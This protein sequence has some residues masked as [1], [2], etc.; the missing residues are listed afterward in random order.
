MLDKR[1][2]TNFNTPCEPKINIK[3][4]KDRLEELIETLHE[5]QPHKRDDLKVLHSTHL[6]QVQERTK[7]P[8]P[9]RLSSSSWGAPEVLPDQRVS[10]IPQRVL[11]LTQ[12]LPLWD[13]KTSK[14]RCPDPNLFN[15][16]Q[17][18]SSCTP[19]SSPHL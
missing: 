5:L 13:R 4:F 16:L 6:Q 9:Q 11:G 7:P 15:C 14:G 3:T 8:P 18:S 2:G 12:A 17:R 10:V 19:S 1:V